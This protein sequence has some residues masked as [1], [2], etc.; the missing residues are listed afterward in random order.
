[1][2]WQTGAPTRELAQQGLLANLDWLT[3]AGHWK[4]NLPPLV[5]PNITVEGHI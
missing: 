4:Q 5:L 3:K 2:Q 1:M